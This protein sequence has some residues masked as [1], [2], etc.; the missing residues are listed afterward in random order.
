MQVIKDR[1]AGNHWNTYWKAKA[2]REYC[3]EIDIGIY[4]R[5]SKERVRRF[6]TRKSAEK[7]MES[8]R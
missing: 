5:D 3:I 6:S 7:A 2:D 1:N 4:T 8:L